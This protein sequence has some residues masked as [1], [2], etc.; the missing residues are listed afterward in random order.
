MIVSEDR[1]DPFSSGQQKPSEA[2]EESTKSILISP[3]QHQ[4]PHKFVTQIHIE[5]ALNRSQSN[6]RS[7]PID[8]RVS[9][10]VVLTEENLKDLMKCKPTEEWVSKAGKAL[11]H[12]YPE[13]ERAH[14][15]DLKAEK[16]NV[17]KFQVPF[18][19]S[20]PSPHPCP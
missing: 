17:Q 11:K 9:V 16:T 12:S 19:S 6:H 20:L 15:E 5:D 1:L 2:K 10:E 14:Q 7:T 8:K 18:S 3:S 4:L 13:L